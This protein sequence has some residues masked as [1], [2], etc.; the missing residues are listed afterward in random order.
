M[1]TPHPSNIA[2][3]RK[4]GQTDAEDEENA[5]NAGS[6]SEL[7]RMGYKDFERLVKPRV[8]AM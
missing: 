7:I 4:T 6:H 1:K 5:F 3:S 2:S 8:V